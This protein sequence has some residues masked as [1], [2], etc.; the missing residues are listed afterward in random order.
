[1]R[2]EKLIKFVT[3]TEIII[4]C[5]I[6]PKDLR[7]IADKMDKIAN[8]AMVGD[9]LIA[10]EWILDGTTRIKFTLDQERATKQGILKHL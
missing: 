9:S 8:T 7:E 1:M 4:T 3:M 6:T 2:R 5:F 10:K